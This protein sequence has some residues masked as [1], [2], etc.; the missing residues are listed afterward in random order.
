MEGER[1]DSNPRP[2]GPQLGAVIPEGG[3]SVAEKRLPGDHA[4]EPLPYPAA[5]RALVRATWIAPARGE[6]TPEIRSALAS[7]RCQVDR[8]GTDER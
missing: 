2:P 7:S 1:R 8:R 6:T 3:G 4:G 5:V